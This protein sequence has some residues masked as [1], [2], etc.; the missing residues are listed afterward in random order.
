VYNLV[1]Y[2]GTFYEFL[3]AG[4]IGFFI[5]LGIGMVELF[6]LQRAFEKMSF[7]KLLLTRTIIYALLVSVALSLVLSIELAEVNRQPYFASVLEYL[8]SKQFERDFIFSFSFGFI[9]I[10]ILQLGQ[11]VGLRNLVKFSFG[12]YHQPQELERIFMF[13]DLK[14]STTIAERLGPKR[15]SNFIKDYFNDISDA[16]IAYKGEV[17]QYVGDEIIVIWPLNDG[18][19]ENR[20]VECFFQMQEIIRRRKSYYLDKYGVWPEFKAG[21]HYGDTVVTEVGKIKKEI[22]YHGDV[23]NTASRIQGKCNEYNQQLIISEALFNKLNLDGKFTGET[24]GAIPLKGKQIEINL[25][26]IHPALG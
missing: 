5:G 14:D 2:P 11:L 19:R 8:Q 21:L 23:L 18:V 4:T 3:E 9:I 22:V 1:F 12:M 20:C 16:I 24:L 25:F 10:F 6:L 17:Y 7:L 13:T 26:G 15:F